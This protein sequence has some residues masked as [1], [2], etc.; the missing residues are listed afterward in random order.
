MPS[1]TTPADDGRDGAFFAG[2][3]PRRFAHRGLAPHGGENTMRAFRAALDAGATHLETDVQ[4]TSDGIALA[5]HDPELD[6]VTDRTGR[7]AEHTHAELGDVRVA[8]TEPIP[9]LAEVLAAF[10]D[11]PLNL[12]VKA[13]RNVDAVVA[14]IVAADAVD[15]VCVAAF[16]GRDSARAAREISQRTGRSPAR[17]AGRIAIALTI[18]A[19]RLRLPHRVVRWILRDAD[20]LQVPERYGRIRVVD[21]RTVAAAHRAGRE[22]HVWTVDATA[23]MRRL[24]ALGVDGLITNRADRLAALLARPAGE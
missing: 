3:L 14:E 23:D 24:L 6:R 21:P 15:R 18:A 10:P 7:V 13:A 8:G 4:T 11:V 16:D 19:V 5:F 2:P 12:D 9:T 17:S 22:V 20:C 1:S